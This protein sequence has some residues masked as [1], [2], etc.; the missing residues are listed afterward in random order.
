MEDCFTVLLTISQGSASQ[1]D[2][3]ISCTYWQL[4]QV[5]SFRISVK[6]L[7]NMYYP[8]WKIVSKMAALFINTSDHTY[9]LLQYFNNPQICKQL[10]CEDWVLRKL[11]NVVYFWTC[12]NGIFFSTRSTNINLSL[13]N[14]LFFTKRTTATI[15]K[16]MSLFI[17]C[18]LHIKPWM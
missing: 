17:M 9:P 6:Y 18:Y 8:N 1:N 4:L 16:R 10:P 13:L 12:H 15:F 7:E 3:K 11:S 14:P 2:T 5:G